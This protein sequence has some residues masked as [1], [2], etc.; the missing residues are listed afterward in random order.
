MAESDRLI[1]EHYR[2]EALEHDLSPTST[3]LDQTTRELEVEAILSCVAH[4]H[5]AG[6]AGTLLEIGCGNGYLLE[7]LRNRFPEIQLCGIDYSPDMV[8][9][10]ASRRLE[11]CEI[12]REDVRAL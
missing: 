6:K 10:G 9:L 7:I 2:R 11:N 3:M 4:L 5:R 8:S 1:L 12:R